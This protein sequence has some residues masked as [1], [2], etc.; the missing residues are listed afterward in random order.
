MSKSQIRPVCMNQ[1]DN[2]CFCNVKVEPNKLIRILMNGRLGFTLQLGL[3]HG[4]Y[5]VNG[6]VLG[7]TDCLAILCCV[8]LLG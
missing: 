2:A 8:F 5:E 3:H 7:C 1:W 4:L 6:Q